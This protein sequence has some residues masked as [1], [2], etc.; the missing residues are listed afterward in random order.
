MMPLTFTNYKSIN[1]HYAFLGLSKG[2]EDTYTFA[3]GVNEHGLS[4]AVLYF[5]GY[6][7]YNDEI[8]KD[9]VN[10]APAEVVSYLLATTKN[11]EEVLEAFDKINITNEMIKFIQTVPP[12]H[13]VILDKTGRSIIIEPLVTGIKVHENK[14]GV[15]ANSPDYDWHL[16]NVRNYIGLENHHKDPLEINGLVFEPFGQGAGAFGMP[17]DFTPPARFIR[18]LFNKL[19][20]E[21]ANGEDNLVI[22]ANN[23]LNSVKIPRGSVITNKKTFD[24]IQHT[25]FMVPKSKSYYYQLYHNPSIIEVKLDDYDLSGNKAIVKI[26]NN[27]P[28]FIK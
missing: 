5:A 11:I 18:T 25:A 4:I 12:F 28:T 21:K 19:T 7:H 27:T 2:V 10:L 8:L 9:K 16:T 26:I 20:V 15:M 22:Q 3:D 14:L 13:W 1:K 23:I 24:Y 6:A 17:G